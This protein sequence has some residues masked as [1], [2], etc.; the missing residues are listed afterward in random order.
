MAKT[1]NEGRIDRSR[2]SEKSF[3][4]GSNTGEMIL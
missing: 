3:P 1:I 4:F 2:G